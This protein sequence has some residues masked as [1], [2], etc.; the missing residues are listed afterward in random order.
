MNLRN[1]TRDHTKGLLIGVLVPLIFVPLVFLI[2]TWVGDY[3]YSQLWVKF[4]IILDYRVKIL[5]L[6]VLS[7][8]IW[9]YVFLN[10]ERYNLAMGIILG[11]MLYAPYVIYIKFF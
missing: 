1:W 8:L 11:S 6:S 10:R 3:Y 7:N 4:K 9:F 2:L 5:T